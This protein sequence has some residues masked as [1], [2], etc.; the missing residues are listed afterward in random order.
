VVDSKGLSSLSPLFEGR[1]PSPIP[2]PPAGG[3]IKKFRE[4]LLKSRS[5]GATGL[6]AEAC[7]FLAAAVTAPASVRQQF[8]RPNIR[9]TAT[10]HLEVIQATVPIHCV[11]P[12]PTNGRVVGV[13]SWAAGDLGDGQTMKLWAPADM[14]VHP[15]APCEVL[16]RSDALVTIKTLMEEAADNTKR[17]NPNMK[18]KVERDGILDP[19]LCQ[20]VHI[21]TLDG[22]SSVALVTRDGSTR[23]S[24]AQEAHRAAAHDAFFGAGRDVDWRRT[25]WQKLKRL[26]ERP[27]GSINEEELIQL[28]T[29]F[30]DVHIVV[31]FLSS[32]PKVSALDAVDDIVR[33]T[34][35]E[36]T[37]PWRPVAQ[38]N[39]EADKVLAA[40]R[41]DGQLTADQFRLFGGQ[42]SRA[43]RSLRGLPVESDEVVARLLLDLGAT[44]TRRGALD[45]LHSAIRAASGRGAIRNTFKAELAGSLGLRQFA[46]ETTLRDKAHVTLGE[47]LS[48]AELWERDWA[49]TTRSP[50]EL[51]DAALA[52]LDDHSQPGPACREL[53][54]KASGHLAAKGWLQGE[55]RDPR[56]EFRD[57]RRPYEVL[58]TMHKLPGGVHALAEALTAGRRG[59]PAR[60]MTAEGEVIEQVAGDTQEMTNQWLRRTF[61]RESEH[62]LALAEPT[63]PF[64]TKTPREIVAEHIRAIERNAGDLRR[65]IEDAE[66]VTDADGSSFLARR[67]WA[68]G[69]V[70]PLARQLDELA[71]KL[72]RYGVIHDLHND[73][74]PQSPQ[75]TFTAIGDPA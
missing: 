24:F 62:E 50:Q 52:E 66:R 38:R 75:M 67:G 40:L 54:V 7:E 18:T 16:L 15:D 68:I 42:I 33:R 5:E 21:V 46:V 2:S 14:A 73:L 27:S 61:E 49:N 22:D 23:C 4:R 51:R 41:N 9:P 43:Q 20:L 71:N 59:E 39:S 34:H 17:L 11:A 36:T 70:E 60:A 8:G 19:L 25:Q 31:G 45:D 3:E 53:L 69:E 10:G 12:D 1:R 55:S 35:V 48:I 44:E 13:T 65:A 63:V 47:A 30:V 58:E 26:S 28:R 6:S 57:Q 56:G 32:D 37:H 64:E 72:S 29:F 74:P